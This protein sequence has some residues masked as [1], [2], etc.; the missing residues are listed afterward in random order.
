MFSIYRP[1]TFNLQRFFQEL[2]ISVDK[3]TG[4]Y[5]M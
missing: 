2:V 1:Q 3:A 5:V 4:A